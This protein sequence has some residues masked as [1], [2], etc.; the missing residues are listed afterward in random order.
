LPGCLK[1]FGRHFENSRLRVKELKISSLNITFKLGDSEKKGPRIF[2]DET[3]SLPLS[4]SSSGIQAVVPIHLVVEYLTRSEN[5]VHSFIVEEPELNL[6]PTAQKDIVNFLVNKCN[7]RND[8]L[9]TTHSPYILSVLNNL[10]FAAIVNSKNEQHKN[11]VKR[12]IPENL[13]VIPNKFNAY[14]FDK[15]SARCIVNPNS[16]LISDNELDNVSEDIIGERNKLV[17]VLRESS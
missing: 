13:W 14:Y 5:S 1:D 10:L 8:L 15:G 4:E 16:E 3:H 12:I 17:D 11:S 7:H 2:Y 6:F 9:I